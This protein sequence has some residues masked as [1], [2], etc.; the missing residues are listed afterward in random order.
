MPSDIPITRAEVEDMLDRIRSSTISRSEM[1]SRMALA[2]DVFLKLQ[3]DQD[4]SWNQGFDHLKDRFVL[5]DYL[6][7]RI[8]TMQVQVYLIIGLQ[9]TVIAALISIALRR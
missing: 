1:D 3:R 7:A 5:R 4:E 6:E 2:S 8:G 9:A